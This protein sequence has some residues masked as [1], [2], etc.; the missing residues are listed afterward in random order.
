MRLLV[1][2]ALLAAGTAAAQTPQ[3]DEEKT[4]YVMGQMVARGFKDFSLS[5]KEAELM[6]R[7][8][9]DAL[10]GKKPL[11]EISAYEQKVQEFAQKR[12]LAAAEKHKEAAKAFVEAAAKEK[13]AQRTASGLVYL[14]LKEGGGENPKESDAV[15][16]NYQGK[17]T[18]GTVFDAS[19]M[20]GG[21]AEFKLAQVIPC[22]REGVQLMKVGGKAR[23]VC[24]SSI[25][26]GDMGVPPKI[27]GGAALVFE[28][29]LLEVKK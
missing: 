14:S 29:E 26:Y 4:L 27:P 10:A 23:L 2:A 6:K 7:G 9:S 16:A 13:G 8:I 21:P 1:L 15:K 3:T 24:P 12:R 22:W 11:V 17:F 20:H 28:V 5:P 19:T 25:A 18:D